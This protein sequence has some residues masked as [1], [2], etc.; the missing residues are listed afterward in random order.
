MT[1]RKI[2]CYCLK[3]SVSRRTYVG[4]S[5]N[6]TRRLRQHNGE[7]VGGSKYTS[8]NRPWIPV[9]IVEGF[10]SWKQALKFEW[11]WKKVK[12]KYG[13]MSPIE[14]RKKC[15]NILLNRDRWKDKNLILIEVK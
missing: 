5:I 7:L 6:L 15:V 2:V 8:S 13:S 14:R 9:Y 4:A 3:S 11:Q 12:C 1:S 10:S